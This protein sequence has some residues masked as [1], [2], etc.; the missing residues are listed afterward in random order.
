MKKEFENELK[1]KDDEY[2]KMIKEQS[3]DV[4]DLIVKN[5]QLILQNQ[6]H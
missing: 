1:R 2:V 6:R 5:A 3:N 4:K